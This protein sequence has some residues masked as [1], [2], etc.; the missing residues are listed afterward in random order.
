MRYSGLCSG[1]LTKSIEPSDISQY[2]TPISSTKVGIYADKFPFHSPRSWA[3]TL[4]SISALEH[5][6]LSLF[7]QLALF[8]M[9][10]THVPII[11]DGLRADQLPVLRS[12]PP[13]S[14][15]VSIMAGGMA[16]MAVDF[17]FFPLDTLKTRLQANVATAAA[18]IRGAAFYRGTCAALACTANHWLNCTP[19]YTAA[20]CVEPQD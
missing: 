8:A 11:E 3:S 9:S 5:L 20:H 4:P 2:S 15:S 10:E 13:T 18:G 6:S 7:L 16:G 19:A 14:P 12:A 1:Q 17:V